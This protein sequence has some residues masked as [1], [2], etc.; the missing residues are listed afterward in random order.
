MHLTYVL[1]HFEYGLPQLTDEVFD[2]SEP[3]LIVVDEHT[4]DI[5]QVVANI[6]TKNFSSQEH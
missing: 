4:S 6:F 3:S 5:N 2:G 1:V